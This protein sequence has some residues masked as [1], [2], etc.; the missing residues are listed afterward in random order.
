MLGGRIPVNSHPL[1]DTIET[2]LAD[3]LGKD[4]RVGMHL[5]PA[6]PTGSP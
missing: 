3:A 1:A 5:G 2:Y 6:R 4:I